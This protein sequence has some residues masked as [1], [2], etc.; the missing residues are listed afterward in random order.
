MSAHAYATAEPAEENVRAWLKDTGGLPP[1]SD[2]TQQPRAA[3][4]RTAVRGDLR[5]R[6]MFLV[7]MGF[8]LG[9]V[10]VIPAAAFLLRL[11]MIQH[12]CGHGSFFARRRLDDWTGRAIGVL[13]R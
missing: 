6:R 5:L 12:D 2:G 3:R 11:F 1:A 7:A 13:T 10:L 9:I 4:H 8:W